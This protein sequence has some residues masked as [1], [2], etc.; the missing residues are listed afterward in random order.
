MELFLKLFDSTIGILS[1]FTIGFIIC[2]AVYLFIW[3]GRQVSAE[4]EQRQDEA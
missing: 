2:M 4:E 3:M 1:I